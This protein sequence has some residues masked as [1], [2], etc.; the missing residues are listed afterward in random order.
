MVEH[1]EGQVAIAI[2]RMLAREVAK[3]FLLVGQKPVIARNPGV[4]LVD[5]AEAPDPIVVLAGADADPGQ[6]VRRGNVALVAPGADEIDDL[7][8]GIVGDPAAF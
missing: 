3:A 8:A 5:L 1:H 7:V 2:E 4:V 6:K